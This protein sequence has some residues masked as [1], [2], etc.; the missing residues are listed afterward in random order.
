MSKILLVEDD[1]VT[2]LLLRRELHLAGYEVSVA[3]NGEEGLQQ[4]RQLHPALIICDWVMPLM[5]GVELCRSVKASP[6]L[7]NI[8]FILLTVREAIAD[9][10]EGLDAGAD[11]FLSKPVNLNELLARVRAGLR[12]YQYQQDLSEANQQLNSTLRDL[13][14]T[15]VQLVQSEKMSSLGQLVAGVA[16]E[17]NNPLGIIEGNLAHATNYL[18]HLLGLMQLYQNHYPN[19]GEEIENY[20]EE[21]DCEFIASDFPKVLESMGS[22]TSR[23]NAIVLSL[24][25]FSRLDEAEMKLVDLHEGLDSTLLVLQHRLQAKGQQ[26][27]IQVIKEYGDL[28]QVECYPRQLNQVFLNIL[29]NAIDAI[30]Y[31]GM[32]LQASSEKTR[33]LVEETETPNSSG[34]TSL[35]ELSYAKQTLAN[36]KSFTQKN[37]V[38]ATEEAVATLEAFN[39]SPEEVCD[40]TAALQGDEESTFNTY[41]APK[42]L[43]SSYVPCI[44]IHTQVI[45]S[46]SQQ[47]TDN[48]QLTID[49]VVIRISDNGSGMTELAKKHLF[50]PF[51]TTKPVG[52]GTGLGLSISYQIV[53]QH[54][55]GN[56]DYKS[57]LGRGTDFFVK[58]PIRQPQLF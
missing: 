9:R 48:G 32:T 15:Q 51:F 20:A 18:T 12:L 10:V 16:H 42:S 25:N 43:A 11:D 3:K 21:N 39:S 52:E 50:D 41:N 37:S 26:L 49:Q 7:A 54:H 14:R 22:G 56:L 24:R 28:P 47:R 58:I 44:T 29:N 13:K 1:S 38:M 31:K 53:V 2:R 35:E 36:V 57:E 33:T 27:R 17:I 30:Q 6:E 8:F 40:Q 45:R 55:G 23:I 5:D 46:Q 19:P 34:E 4:A